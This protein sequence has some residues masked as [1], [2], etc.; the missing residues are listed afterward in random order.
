MEVQAPYGYVLN[1]EPVYFDVMQENSEID[2]GI[3][4]I[5]V[6]RSN[7]AQKGT[8]TVSKS[9]EVFSSVNEAG[10]LYQ[11]AYAVRGLEG[12]VY[13]ITAA[14]DIYTLDGTL[15]ASKGEVLWRGSPACARKVAVTRN[16]FVKKAYLRCGEFYCRIKNTRYR[17][18]R[19]TYIKTRAG[20]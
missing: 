17:M 7:V 3:T 2:S 6:V 14:E 15:R 11:P 8:I 18:S 10:G 5:E 4:V 19:Q 13:E 1:S 20:G 16:I 9:G 12:A